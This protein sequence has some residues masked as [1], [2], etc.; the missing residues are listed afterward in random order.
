MRQKLEEIRVIS[1]GFLDFSQIS[2]P[3]L[4]SILRI[5]PTFDEMRHNSPVGFEIQEIVVSTLL[6]YGKPI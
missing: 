6:V 5:D 4:D 1:D 2:K 3:K